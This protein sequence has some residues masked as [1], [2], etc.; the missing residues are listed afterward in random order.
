MPPEREFSRKIVVVVGGASGI[1][2]DVAL[3]I[4]RRG[5][6]VVVADQNVAAAEDGGEGSG[7]ALLEG[8]GA[9]DARSI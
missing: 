1:G 8:D 3:Q 5:G 2:R 7:G 4:A 6:H 9:R